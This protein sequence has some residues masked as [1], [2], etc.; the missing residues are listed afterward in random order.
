MKK[1]NF[2]AL[3]FGF[4]ERLDAMIKIIGD[5]I[6]IPGFGGFS[7]YYIGNFFITGLSKGSLPSAPKA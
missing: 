3:L 7:L 6:V 5:K 2:R 1:F 4:L